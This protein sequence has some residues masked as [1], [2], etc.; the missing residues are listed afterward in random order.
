M[1]KLLAAFLF[2]ST[3]TVGYSLN[4]DYGATLDSY[5]GSSMNADTTVFGFEKLSLY[6]S[7]MFT[8]DTSLALDGY[9]KFSY[10]TED[11]ELTHI[12]DFNT[13]LLGSAF[14]IGNNKANY[15]IGRGYK[16]DYA[17]DIFAHNLDAFSLTVP[18]S[19]ATLYGH[20]GFTGLLHRDEDTL[21]TSY[22]DDKKEDDEERGN[23]SHVIEGVD[24]VTETD[25]MTFWGSLYG[26]QDIRPE[27]LAKNI[28]I[29]VGAG[30]QGSITS[31]IYYSLRGNFKTGIFPY[32]ESGSEFE[33]ADTALILAGMGA[34]SLDWFIQAESLKVFRPLVSFKLG[35]SSGDSEL[36]LSQ[37]GT[38][39]GVKIDQVNQYSPIISS[40]PGNIYS[41]SNTNLTYFKL[42][43]SVTPLEKL[44]TTVGT[45]MFF[46]TVKGVTGDTNIS[47]DSDGN[48]IGT[49]ISLT[50]NYRLFSDL[51]VS[52]SGGFNIPNK[53][54]TGEDPSGLIAAYVSLS[55]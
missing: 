29:Y 10:T 52:V 8:E 41:T 44:Q 34:M 43:A 49:E 54:V 5:V 46:R 6:G 16:S 21:I 2:I 50:A 32:S 7:F 26:Y 28:G 22:Q 3:L 12:L 48:Y 36:T 20:V 9:Y 42:D 40:G 24:L 25:N 27:N 47:K 45:T 13:L 35:A 39:Q 1:K 17:G 55:L 23:V 38:N 31:S 11:N 33:A 51:G 4:I 53:D 19:F 37:R 18:L 30:F 14:N 15:Q